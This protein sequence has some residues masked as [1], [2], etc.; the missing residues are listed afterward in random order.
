MTALMYHDVVPAGAEDTTG[1]PGRDAALYKVTPETFESHLAAIDGEGPG[2]AANPVITFDDGGASA[3]GAAD[4]LERRGRRGHFFMTVDYIG[5]AGFLDEAAL[6]DL[7]R[8]GHVVGSHSCS[9]PLRMAHCPDRQIRAE[10]ADSRARLCDLLGADV[11]VASVPGGD[12]A[13]RVADAAAEAGL[14]TLFT[15]EPTTSVRRVGGIDVHGRFT[16]RRWTTPATAAA[17]AR[18]EWLPCARQ[19]ATWTARKIGKRACG[20]AYLRLRHLLLR[21]GN[22]VRWGDS[23]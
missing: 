20:G 12:Y 18:G 3:L 21:P 22:Q 1:F 13:D 5:A 16:I 7:H 8:R 10:W 6:R 11:T 15:S 9:H 19:A 4:A 14:Q 2:R 23:R 17:L